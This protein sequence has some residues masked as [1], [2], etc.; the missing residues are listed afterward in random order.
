MRM[1]L[2]ST[3]AQR[4]NHT[5]RVSI[6]PYYLHPEVFNQPD[7]KSIEWAPHPAMMQRLKQQ[8]LEA[9]NAH[10]KREKHQR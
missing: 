5:P 2:P 10:V 4:L 6:I 1:V 9:E 8:R 7:E 3:Q